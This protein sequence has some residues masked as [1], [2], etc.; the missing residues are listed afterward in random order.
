VQRRIIEVLPEHYDP[1]GPWPFMTVRELAAAVYD[2]PE[3]TASHTRAVHRAL[4]R[5]T[6]FTL[7]QSANR[8][9]G[10]GLPIRETFVGTN[11]ADLE[12]LV[13]WEKE[14]RRVA[15]EDDDYVRQVDDLTAGLDRLADTFR[16]DTTPTN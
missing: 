11:T 15:A 5:M 4:S 12:L 13:A 3:P 2:V 7:V 6:G 8:F 14:R 16:P 1:A 10:D 9:R